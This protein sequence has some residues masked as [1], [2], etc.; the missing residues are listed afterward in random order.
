MRKLVFPEWL[1]CEFLVA[2]E[3]TGCGG[4]GKQ[5]EL[6]YPSIARKRDAVRLCFPVIC[7]CGRL[8]GLRVELPI[9][10]FGYMLGRIALIESEGR[11][12]KSAM[13]VSPKR[14][15]LFIR[16]MRDFET[17]LLGFAAV[18]GLREPSETSGNKA[19]R[20][21]PD[22]PRDWER[23]GFGLTEQEWETFLRRLG[24]GE[25]EDEPA[26]DRPP[27]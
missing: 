10:L 14:S 3:C 11:R 17:D 27:F 20:S 2:W 9:L 5:V 26:G 12:R 7:G 19:R 21:R 8:G 18:T 1:L 13:S 23:F 4:S 22:E 15:D 24:F 25:E 16:F 6:K